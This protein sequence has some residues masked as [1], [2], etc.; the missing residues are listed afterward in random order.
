MTWN[1]RVV[2][3][4]YPDGEDEYSIHEVYYDAYDR[5]REIT[6]DAVS[7]CTDELS[8]LPALRERVMRAFAKAVLEYADFTEDGYV[9]DDA[10]FGRPLAG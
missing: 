9:G 10:G 5:P 1:Y 8:D 7:I 6:E 3:H 4:R 2:H